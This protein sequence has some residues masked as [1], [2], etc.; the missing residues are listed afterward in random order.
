[1]SAKSYVK[2]ILTHACVCF[3]VTA[4][5]LLVLY[6]IINADMTRG[7]H[8]LAL[9]LIFP[10]SLFFATAN[11]LLRH[12]PWPRSLAVTVHFILTVGGVMLFLYLPN[13]PAGSTASGGLIFFFFV[14]VAYAV[15]MGIIALV[16]G[17]A[18]R[19]RA[20]NKDY[21]SVYKK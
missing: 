10:F 4:F 16:R 15:V 11:V 6:W 2:K 8:P 3:T 17:R 14:A 19:L 1:M 7:L 5:L 9:V 21:K 13:R 18:K 12:A 20:E